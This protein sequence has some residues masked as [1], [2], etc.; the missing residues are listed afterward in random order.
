MN[1][2]KL[3]TPVRAT[4]KNPN[5]QFLGELGKPRKYSLRPTLESPTLESMNELGKIMS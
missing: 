2:G 5:F 3:R 4:F 1:L